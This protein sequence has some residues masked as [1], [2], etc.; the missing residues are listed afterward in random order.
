MRPPRVDHVRESRDI[1]P[2]VVA[3]WGRLAPA[4]GRILLAASGGPDST[5][6]VVSA[7]AL[8]PAE[9]LHVVTVDH[10][11]RPESADDAR[12]AV[13][14][15][16]RLGLS[17]EIVTLDRPVAK[18][19]EEEA[20]D[21]RYAALV[22]AATRL[23][24]VAVATGHHADDQT[25]TILFRILRGTGPAGLAGIPESR[26]LVPGSEVRLIRPLLAVRRD[27]LLRYLTNG[28]VP[29]RT[30]PT[31]ADP[32][33]RR[34]R[35]RHEV[36][37]LLRDVMGRTVDDA[38]GRLARQV[39]EYHATLAAD[40]ADVRQVL[41]EHPETTEGPDEVAWPT[42]VL[43][44]LDAVRIRILLV[45]LWDELAWPRRAMNRDHWNSAAEV[46]LGRLRAVD[47]PGGVSARSRQGMFVLRRVTPAVPDASSCVDSG[48]TAD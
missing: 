34:N 32:D 2:P 23:A 28:D 47:L 18:I 48:P 14:L 8:F 37:P 26:P 19:S 4:E 30:D 13:G 17:A 7:A 12:H 20:R 10:R 35:L 29:Y 11:T 1:P 45:D 46:A 40:A 36:L 3:A 16:R 33:Y 25:E 38:L 24:A 5:A 6:L 41:R 21:S 31:N 39:T 22:E 27:A 43:E 9:R 42:G 44:R 15:A